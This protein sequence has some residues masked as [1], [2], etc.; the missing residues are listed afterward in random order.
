[1]N[2]KIIIELQEVKG[3]HMSMKMHT[4]GCPCTRAEMEAGNALIAHLKLWRPP[5]H[6][7][8]PPI[9]ILD[10]TRRRPDAN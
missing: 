1:M 3:G 5:N 10:T 6:E 2:I 8:L 7:A 4:E 9:V